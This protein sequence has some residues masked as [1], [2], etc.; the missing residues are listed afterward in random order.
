MIFSKDILTNFAKSFMVSDLACVTSPP[1][2]DDPNKHLVIQ[3]A[4]GTKD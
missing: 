1:R 3:I 4:L 2:S